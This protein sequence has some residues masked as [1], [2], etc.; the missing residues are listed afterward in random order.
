MAR[1]ATV[2]AITATSA[3][4]AGLL[5]GCGGSGGHSRPATSSQTASATTASAPAGRA[6]YAAR[7]PSAGGGQSSV[8]AAVAAAPISPVIRSAPS[9]TP[10]GTPAHAADVA[11]IRGWSDALRHGDVAGAARYFQLPSELINGPDA[12]GR[13]SELPIGTERAAVA[14]NELLPCGATL[15]NTD[16]RGRWIDALFIIGTRPGPG[17]GGCQGTRTTARVYFVV[18]AG[19]IV[20]WVRAP[21]QAGDDAVLSG[22]PSPGTSPSGPPMGPRIIA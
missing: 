15:V 2:A 14:A 5:A 10:T 7:Q 17:G 13:F 8:A 18:H 22:G 20:D 11:V 19:R 21:P 16:L 1:A 4:A 6:R 3:L 12:D 9:L